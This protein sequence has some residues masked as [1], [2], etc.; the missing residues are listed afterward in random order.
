MFTRCFV[1]NT[2]RNFFLPYKASRSRFR[3]ILAVSVAVI[4]AAGIRLTAADHAACARDNATGITIAVTADI[5]TYAAKVVSD[6]ILAHPCVAAVLIAGDAANSTPTPL[7][8]YQKIYKGTYNRFISKIYPCPGNHDMLS[9]PPFSAYC[10]FFG[11]VAH[12]PEMYY[13]FDLGGWHIVSLNSMSV[14]IT[15]AQLDWLKS[16]LAANPKTPII[17]FWHHPLFSNARHC[18]SQL[19]KP[20]WEAIYAHGPAII[21]NGHNHVYERFAP[22]DPDGRPVDE[23]N[24]IR[25]FVIGPGGGTSPTKSE[26]SEAKGP[27]SEKF[28]GGAQ[29]VGFFTLYADG[30]YSFIINTV[31]TNGATTVVDSGAGNLKGRGLVP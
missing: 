24:G 27:A 14:A 4:L 29:H 26:S 5:T 17:A 20:F 1:N 8:S 9:K 10:D 18:G 11:K 22:F 23:T 15:N 28:H 25:E 3:S 19:R 30:G 12:A 13:S 2:I 6:V 31:S 21:F 16:D 7:E